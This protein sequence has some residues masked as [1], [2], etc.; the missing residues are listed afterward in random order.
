MTDKAKEIAR[1]LWHGRKA[2]DEVIINGESMITEAIE[3]PKNYHKETKEAWGSLMALFV[4]R[5]ALNKRDLPLFRM[6]FDNLDFYYTASETIE[7]TTAGKAGQGRPADIYGGLKE[8]IAARDIFARNFQEYAKI[9]EKHRFAPVT[10]ET[11]REK[12]IDDDEWR[13]FEEDNDADE[14][15][16]YKQWYREYHGLDDDADEGEE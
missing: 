7:R 16:E 6:M 2:Y 11:I 5:E 9:F 12:A 1:N 10:A 4:E 3:P 8:T 14:W 15:E 13:T